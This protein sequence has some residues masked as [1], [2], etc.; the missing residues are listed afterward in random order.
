MW[1]GANSLSQSRSVAANLEILKAL[2]YLDER[3]SEY[4]VVQVWRSGTSW[5]RVWNDGFI[6][7]G[8]RVE[9]T[10]AIQTITLHK[11]FASTDYIAVCVGYSQ[12]GLAYNSMLG[13]GEKTAH[14][15]SFRM[16]D[17]GGNRSNAQFRDW[18]AKGY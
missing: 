2:S 6:E 12:T 13:A 4:R 10:A 9:N 18:F 5:Y 7:Q 1:R 3:S 17:D 15:F 16:V 11:P 14:S 8:G